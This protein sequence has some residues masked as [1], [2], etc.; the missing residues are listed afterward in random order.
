MFEALIETTGAESVEDFQLV[1]KDG[2]IELGVLAASIGEWRVV[3]V[4]TGTSEPECVADLEASS[5][6]LAI[7]LVRSFLKNE[8]AGA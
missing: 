1:M 5:L 3:A 6:P 2:D 8:Y 7:G 4:N